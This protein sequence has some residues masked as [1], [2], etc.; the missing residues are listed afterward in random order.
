LEQAHKVRK[1]TF[2]IAIIILIVFCSFSI[3]RAEPSRLNI[4]V[5]LQLNVPRDNTN[6]YN[7]SCNLFSDSLN[8]SIPKNPDF[9]RDTVRL[10]PQ[11]SSQTGVRATPVNF[12]LIFYLD[13]TEKI[14]ELGNL[15]SVAYYDGVVICCIDGVKS[16]NY[17]LTIVSEINGAID[18]DRGIQT[19]ISI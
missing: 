9:S 12:K 13:R 8:F 16:G 3:Y 11:P 15:L 14:V 10:T 19:E 2:A 1:K 18:S 4:S 7:G 6:N 5:F 17:N